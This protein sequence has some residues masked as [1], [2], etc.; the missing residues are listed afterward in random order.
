MRKRQI[1]RVSFR[2][3]S[4]YATIIQE[5]GVGKEVF[6]IENLQHLSLSGQIIQPQFIMLC[7]CSHGSADIVLNGVDHH[8]VADDLLLVFADSVVEHIRWSED[9]SIMA[10]VQER[11]FVQE[12]LMSMLQLWPYLVQL[13]RMPVLHLS[14]NALERVRLNYRLL[15]LR[16][17]QT[18]HAF[19]REAL[20]SSL[21]AAYFDVCDLLRREDMEAPM[22]NYRSM[23]VFERFM[24][25]LSQEYVRHRDIQWYARELE[26]SPKHLSGSVKMVSGRTAGSWIVMFVVAEIKSMLRN[27]DMSLKEMSEELHFPDQ[28]AF[29]K[30][31][32]KYAGVTPTEFRGS[33]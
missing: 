9:F 33:L 7:L 21:Q 30:Y 2:A 11:G 26:M 22:A 1:L 18:H 6:V 3:A 23:S 25:L 29:G 10:L 13:M 8:I 32:R 24:R 5:G 15:T 17:C 12:T 14:R 4:R 28:S 19:R 27:T 16:L 20:M 31:F